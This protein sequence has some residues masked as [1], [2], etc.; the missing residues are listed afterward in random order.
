MAAMRRL[1]L[2]ALALAACETR[3]PTVDTNT[4]ITGRV[5]DAETNAPLANVVI[6]TT[7]A[8]QRIE[9]DRDGRFEIVEGPKVATLYQVVARLDGYESV[10]K[11]I[12]T[13]PIQDNVVEFSLT[14]LKIC[15]PGQTR[16]ALGT[17]TPGIETCAA[18]GNLWEVMDCPADQVCELAA[19]LP[20]YAITVMTVG[21]G[22]GGIVSSPGGI[23]CGVS[24]TGRF[25]AGRTIMLTATPFA[26]SGF[27]GWTGGCTGTDPTCTVVVDGD[28]TATARFEPTG[29]TLTVMT[30]GLGSGQVRSDPAG[31]VCGRGLTPGSM[32]SAAYM[33]DQ[34]VTLTVMPRAGSTFGGWS[35]PCSGTN[36]TCLVTMNQSR[37]VGARFDTQ[38]YPLTVT[39]AG[40]GIGLVSSS[41]SG[42]DCGATCM[43]DFVED[44]VVTLTASAAPSSTFVAWSGDCTGSAGCTVTMDQ[45]RNVNVTFDGISYP[46]MV[47]KNGTGTGRVVSSPGGIDCGATCSSVFAPG[48]LTLTAMPDP[49]NN[50]VAWGGACAAAAS[51]PTCMLN[52]S[53]PANVSAQF[54]I[55][56]V[57][58][59]V[60]VTGNGAITSN[61]AGIDCGA[62]CMASYSGGT[63]V[64]LTAA[65]QGTDV[66]GGWG[67]ACGF[68]NLNPTCMLTLNA[69]ASVNAVFEPFYLRPFTA[70]GASAGLY[71]FDNPT[72]LADAAGGPAAVLSGTWTPITSRST[73]LAEAYSAGGGEEGFIA[74]N[75]NAPAPGNATIEM[76]VRKAGLAFGAR[77]RAALYS[78]R[79]VLAPGPGVRLSVLDDGSIIIETRAAGGLTTAATAAAALTDNVWAHVAATIGAAGVRIFVDGAQVAQAPGPLMWAASS[80][81]AWIG[82]EREGPGG[83]IHRFNGAI[84]EVRI[85]N[86]ARY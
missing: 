66:F 54:D 86:T 80:S 58:L 75:E 65:A 59:A 79:D 47:T 53:G 71:H 10:T 26:L 52:L 43:S 57:S 45:A 76:T 40:T 8:T 22:S 28:K 60:S 24:C 77:T 41:P 83:A 7:P 70:D 27:G 32:C 37:T 18:R 44:D 82:A 46:V 72:P 15:S 23:N 21:G 64:T 81:T 68:A 73:A 55:G 42:I 62:T 69:N 33:I 38:T 12:T 13:S 4:T 2:S 67:G 85:S 48:P 9:T 3:D 17:T 20:S 56:M 36:T 63:A 14:I 35:G 1:L 50:F 34:M 61:P 30:Q 25:P 6:E 84:D 74:T 51:N 11:T 5:V 19:C 16:C 29:Y 78:D 39:R 31:I 49:V